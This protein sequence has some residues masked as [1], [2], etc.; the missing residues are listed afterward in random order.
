MGNLHIQKILDQ[1]YDADEFGLNYNL[2]AMPIKIKKPLPKAALY[3]KTGAT[4]RTDRLIREQI[5]TGV[6]LDQI[7]ITHVVIVP[8]SK[9]AQART[10]KK[11][12]A[13]R[14]SHATPDRTRQSSSAQNA[15]ASER[16]VGIKIGIN[17]QELANYYERER[18]RYLELSSHAALLTHGSR[19]VKERAQAHAILKGFANGI[20]HPEAKTVA[21]EQLCTL[22][23]SVNVRQLAHILKVTDQIPLTVLQR[24]RFMQLA[25]RAVLLNK[26]I[27]QPILDRIMRD[28]MGAPITNDTQPCNLLRLLPEIAELAIEQ[29]VWGQSDPDCVTPG[30]LRSYVE[31][32]AAHKTVKFMPFYL[33]TIKGCV[34][35]IQRMPRNQKLRR[36]GKA[37]M[38]IAFADSS[39]LLAEPKLAPASA[40]VASRPASRH[41]KQPDLPSRAA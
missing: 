4:E 32:L 10:N 13:L 19:K 17:Q 31:N 12:H 40:A 9:T 34:K 7:E 26:R 29:Q 28:E 11:K 22:M 6:A 33:A 39:R 18:Q 15:E 35:D 23:A 2:P 37:H 8:G 1:A 21:W 24:I 3:V 41:H 27:V 25:P 5:R 30:D 36:E 38:E 14:R 20:H 16:L